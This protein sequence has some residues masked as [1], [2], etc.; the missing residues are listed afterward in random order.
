MSLGLSQCTSQ[1]SHLVTSSSQCYDAATGAKVAGNVALTKPGSKLDLV[2][3]GKDLITMS[4]K[5]M[6]FFNI[7][8]SVHS[9]S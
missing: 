7:R 6:W 8:K 5:K 2:G 3:W 1:V 4:L 9:C